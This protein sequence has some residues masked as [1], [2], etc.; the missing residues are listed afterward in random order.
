MRKVSSDL[1]D[2]G[3]YTET[4]CL[5][6]LIGI[7]YGNY[8]SNR[9]VRPLDFPVG[10]VISSLFVIA[11]NSRGFTVSNSDKLSSSDDVLI[12]G[13]AVAKTSITLAIYGDDLIPEEI[14]QLLGYEAKYIRR[15]E[16]RNPRASP[17]KKSAWLFNQKGEAPI[18]A[19]EIIREIL[20]K[21][22]TDSGIWKE[23]ASRYDVQV[24]I[25]IHMKNWNQG[26]DLSAETIQ[27][28]AGLGAKMV[29]D[30]YAYVD[31]E[32]NDELDN[33]LANLAEQQD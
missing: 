12:V 16:R 32:V 23:L 10:A 30:I 18:T 20:S 26:F 5:S 7:I 27:Q 1:A 29:F 19:E 28:I 3:T 25:A 6:A 4:F 14:S 13:G 31:D 11:K 8:L 22:L 21:I 15:G 9:I 2:S 33:V 24:R 17:Y